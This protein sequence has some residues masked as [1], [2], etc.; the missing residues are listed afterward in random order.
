MNH[1]TANLLY[2]ILII[3]GLLLAVAIS[4][5][6]SREHHHVEARF[7][8]PNKI[9]TL[10]GEICLPDTLWADDHEYLED[11]WK[12]RMIIPKPNSGE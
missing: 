6:P 11:Y 7:P 10:R 12:Q 2:P 8:Y 4:H 3:A 5:A 1:R 9:D